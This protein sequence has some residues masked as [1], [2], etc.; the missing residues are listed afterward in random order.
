MHRRGRTVGVRLWSEP[1]MPHSSAAVLP[2][3]GHDANASN[4]HCA[5][6]RAAVSARRLAGDGCS[7][8]GGWWTLVGSGR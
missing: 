4:S 6:T 5:R 7:V 1:G 3:P 8:T 2:L